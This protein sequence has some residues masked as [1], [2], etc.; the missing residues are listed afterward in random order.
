MTT[1]DGLPLQTRRLRLRPYRESD[2]SALFAVFSDPRVMRYWSSPAWTP[3]E[4]AHDV[5]ARDQ[6][7]IRTGSHLGLAIEGLE[8]GVLLGQCTLY[9]WSKQCRR[10]EV[11]YC[12]GSTGWGQ[13]YMAEALGALITYGFD[14][15]D[16][17]RIEADIDPRNHRSAALLEKLGFVQEGFLRERWIVGDE[18]SDSA[19]YGLLRRNWRAR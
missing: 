3:I 13:G 6:E 15:M 2:A 11:G 4:Q 7:G 14:A 10:A 12:L 1:F 17:N 16:L 18:I 9:G 5:I 19:L 8:D